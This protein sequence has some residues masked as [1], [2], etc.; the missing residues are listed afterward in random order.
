M[1]TSK[2]V[3]KVLCWRF[4]LDNDAPRLGRPVEVDRNPID[5]LIENNQYST[6]WELANILKISKCTKVISENEKC[7]FFFM[8][9]TMDFWSTQ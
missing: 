7:V 3:C 2:V 5:T 8:E 4:S 6:T 9:K 1:N